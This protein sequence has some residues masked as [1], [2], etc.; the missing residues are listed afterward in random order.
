MAASGASPDVGTRCRSRV[1]VGRHGCVRI[2]LSGVGVSS[3]AAGGPLALGRLGAAGV[4][5]L[6]REL[7]GVIPAGFSLACPVARPSERSLAL[8]FR[9][10]FPWRSVAGAPAVVAGP[11]S[12][13]SFPFPTR[14]RF[15]FLSLCVLVW[16][17]PRPV[18]PDPPQ[19]GRPGTYGSGRSPGSGGG[20]GKPPG[21][22][23]ELRFGRGVPVPRLRRRSCVPVLEAACGG[24]SRS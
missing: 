13:V 11:R 7:S 21:G 10:A 16:P 24:R 2:G 9:G 3:G 22:W 12:A 4:V 14:R 20:G 1:S 5:G 18:L 23:E 15:F 19:G 17:T 8:S 6:L